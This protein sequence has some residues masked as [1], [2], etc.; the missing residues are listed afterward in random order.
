MPP[1]A[2]RS[3]FV[4]AALCALALAA[5]GSVDDAATTGS[6]D[7]A[8]DVPGVSLDGATDDSMPPNDA[9]ATMDAPRDA[10]RDAHADAP[11]DAPRDV[12][13]DAAVDHPDVPAAPP[14][15]G[16]TE[17]NFD[18]IPW[19]EPGLGVAYRDSGNPRGDDVFIGY[20]GYNVTA[21]AARAW[22]TALFHATLHDHGVRHVY[23][24][25]GPRDVLYAAQ[26]IGNSHLIAQMLPRLVPG[27]RVLVAAHSSGA[28]VAH[29]FLGQLFERGLDPT[30]LTAGRVSYWDLDGGSSGY[31]ATIAAS[32]HHG[33]F[34]WA[35]AGAGGTRSPN[36]STMLALGAAHPGAGGAVRL[37]TGGA[38]CNA[39]AV[40]C[41]HMT[42]VTT[43]P[44]DPANASAALDYGSFDATHRVQTAWLEATGY[45]V[46]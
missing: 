40:W 24:V 4:G 36:A 26:E 13:H 44:H 18:A 41:M 28:Y 46:P 25:Q 10:A 35:E 20:A 42:L 12:P 7:A 5:C 22:V 43:R 27:A 3:R 33:Y 30:H 8:T 23:A 29:E 39:G 14:D 21:D 31:D 34:V 17:P 16:P 15:A 2:E 45:G 37:D 11:G 9:P 1:R 19:S 38:G 6:L 32:V